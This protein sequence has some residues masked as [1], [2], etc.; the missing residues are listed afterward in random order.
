MWLFKVK[1]KT[2][3]IYYQV[4]ATNIEIRHMYVGIR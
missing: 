1:V 3:L 4:C 2:A